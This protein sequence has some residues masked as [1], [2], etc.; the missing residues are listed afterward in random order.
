MLRD[1]HKINVNIQDKCSHDPGG[2]DK[3]QIKA[4]LENLYEN[5]HILVNYKLSTDLHTAF[6]TIHLLIEKGNLNLI[7]NKSSYHPFNYM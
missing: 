4:Y 6:Q 7:H 3:Y 1:K 2:K 5:L